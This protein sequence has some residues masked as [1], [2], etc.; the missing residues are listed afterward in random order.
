MTI[1]SLH[2]CDTA[3]RFSEG[4]LKRAGDIIIQKLA[5]LFTCDGTHPTSTFTH[6][7]AI[8]CPCALNPEASAPEIRMCVNVRGNY[9]CM[10]SW[11]SDGDLRDFKAGVVIAL[12]EAFGPEVPNDF[13]I[14]FEFTPPALLRSI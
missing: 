2:Y 5:N 6:N 3:Y 1:I 9:P 4:A 7:D 10:P 13:E 8:W 12:R 14:E 11:V